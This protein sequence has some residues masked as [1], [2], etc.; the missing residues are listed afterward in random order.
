MDNKEIGE[1]LLFLRKNKNISRS[2]FSK[3]FNVSPSLV[4][5]W[6][7]GQILPDKTTINK[8]SEFYGITSDEIINHKLN[9]DSNF[10]IKEKE[11]KE[12]PIQI[13]DNNVKTKKYVK[14]NKDNKYYK[15]EKGLLIATLILEII[16]FFLMYILGYTLKKP[17]SSGLIVIGI[18]TIIYSIYLIIEPKLMYKNDKLGNNYKIRF[19]IL[20]HEI[21]HHNLAL[22]VSILVLSLIFIIDPYTSNRDILNLKWFITSSIIV[23]GVIFILDIYT[24]SYFY[25]DNNLELPKKYKKL[26]LYI[27]DLINLNSVFYLLVLILLFSNFGLNIMRT[28]GGTNYRIFTLISDYNTPLFYVSM[29]IILISI[30]C[31]IIFDIKNI[32]PSISYGLLFV[33]SLL[34]IISITIIHDKFS[35]DFTNNYTIGFR[36]IVISYI[37]ITILFIVSLIVLLINKKRYRKR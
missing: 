11:V 19:R 18:S 2:Q 8:L 7:S 14:P 23:V 6:E 24:Y 16:S 4:Q 37:I 3:K 32:N 22:Y 17:L 12:K 28:I 34:D 1:F 5:K 31:H 33:G 21:G 30:I 20:K 27:K 26:S 10:K 29:G 25:N 36:L 9:D 35:N 13:N 15:I